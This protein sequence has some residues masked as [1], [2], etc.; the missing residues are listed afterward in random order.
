MT[1]ERGTCILPLGV[2]KDIRG[3]TSSWRPT[4]DRSIDSVM[5][6]LIEEEVTEAQNLTIIDNSTS[7]REETEVDMDSIRRRKKTKTEDLADKSHLTDPSVATAKVDQKS[8][9]KKAKEAAALARMQANL[10]FLGGAI[11]QADEE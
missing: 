7:S 8:E 5:A 4:Y 6:I 10:A 3:L 9:K 11:S 2:W 1:E